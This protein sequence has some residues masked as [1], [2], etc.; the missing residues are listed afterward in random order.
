MILCLRQEDPET[1]I[2]IKQKLKAFASNLYTKISKKTI[3]GPENY[4]YEQLLPGLAV[5]KKRHRD[6]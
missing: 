1:E 5:L 6:E 2:K 4:S 3:V